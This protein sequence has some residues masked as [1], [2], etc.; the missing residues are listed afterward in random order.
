VSQQNGASGYF[1]LSNSVDTNGNGSHFA[2]KG[3][4]MVWSLGPDQ[5]ADASK[6]AVANPNEDNILS[7]R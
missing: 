1:G 2:Y 6:S 4:V 5:K 7:W 3:K